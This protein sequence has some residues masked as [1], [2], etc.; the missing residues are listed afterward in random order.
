MTHDG[1]PKTSDLQEFLVELADVAASGGDVRA[2]IADTAV[3]KPDNI[4]AV[5]DG[6]GSGVIWERGK[7]DGD[8]EAQ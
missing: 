2:H 6:D 3:V 4:T 5:V 1:R 8:T 7:Q